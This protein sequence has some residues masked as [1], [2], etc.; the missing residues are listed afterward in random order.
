MNLEKNSCFLNINKAKHVT[1]TDVVNLVKKLLRVKKCGHAGTLDPI[2]TGVLPIALNKATKLVSMIYENDKEYLV[3]AKMGIKTDTFDITGN[4]IKIS[5]YVPEKD[6][7]L[8]VIENFIG[9]IDLE[10]P[11]YSAVK[12]NGERAYNLARKNLI[13]S[14]G[15]KKSKIY[16]IDFISYEYPYFKLL[17]KCGK[18][19][20]IRSLVNEIGLKMGSF[21]TVVDLVRLRVGKFMIEDAIPFGKLK[22]GKITENDVVSI[23]NI[24]DL[25]R[26]IVRDSAKDKI[27]NGQFPN[28][29]ECI[30]LPEGKTYK[31]A[32]Y[33]ESNELLGVARRIDDK[34]GLKYKI[35][36]MLVS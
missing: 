35:E 22:E 6:E 28:R 29:S 32:I 18:G 25:P 17:I 24:L 20:Y 8:K 26:I 15:T 16:D 9:E 31:A 27:K 10:I 12:I 3:T 13:S 7:L 5:E 21:A 34:A 2:A 19:T 23:N 14:C 11:I 4:T 30:F 1:S 33:D 36:K